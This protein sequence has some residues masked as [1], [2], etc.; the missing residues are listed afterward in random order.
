MKTY[1]NENTGQVVESEKADP[2]L[3]SLNEWTEL[4]D[5]DDIAEAKSKDTISPKPD[6][7][8]LLPE[9]EQ[10]VSTRGDVASVVGVEVGTEPIAEPIEQELARAADSA[11]APTA[12]AAGDPDGPASI[13]PASPEGVELGDS[14]TDYAESDKPASKPAAKGKGK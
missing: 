11:G 7:I 4:T 13:N 12:H 2:R 8:D 10:P 5:A 3:D 1:R 14:L 9:A 6:T